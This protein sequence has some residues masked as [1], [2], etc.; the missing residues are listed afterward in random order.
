H[1]TGERRL[2]VLDQE[3]RGLTAILQTL[4]AHQRAWQQPGLAEDL[5]AVARA[6]HEPPRVDEVGERR[7]HRRAPGDGAG[8]PVVPAPESAWQDQAVEPLEIRLAVPD[9]AHGLAEHLADDVVK[10]AITP[11]AGEH[12]HAEVHGPKVSPFA[13]DD[14][15]LFAPSSGKRP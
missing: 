6:E 1:R 12:H 4:V 9:V 11:R 5:K 8:S 3:V 14:N 7:H 2:V 10:I 15:L 13:L